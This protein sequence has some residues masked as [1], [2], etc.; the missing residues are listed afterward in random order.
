MMTKSS[1]GWVDWESWEALIGLKGVTLDR[2]RGSIH[3]QHSDI[4][5]PID[6]GYVNGTTSSDGQEVDIF[7]GSAQNGL[8]AAIFTVDRR[9]VD[10]ECK[11]IHNCTPEEIY[12][13]NGFINY[14]TSLMSGSLFMRYPM[15]DLYPENLETA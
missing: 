1:P 10:R 4:V 14:D 6:Y 12:L 9:K 8:I 11:L 5:Y 3:P 2:P 7:V 13:I 15:K